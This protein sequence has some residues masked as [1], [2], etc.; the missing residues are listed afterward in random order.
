MTNPI[1]LG[2]VFIASLFIISLSFNANAAT[3]NYTVNDGAIAQ[4]LTGKKGD[5]IS[6]RKVVINRRLGNCL[7]CHTMPI[8]EQS[9]QGKIGPN[10]AGV[11]SRYKEGQL[12]L[13]I[14]NP[15]VVNPETF[16]P[17]YYRTK[18]LHRV[19]KKW[20]G[21]TILSA[22]QVEDVVAYL[23]TLREDTPFKSAFSWA[24]KAKL[25]EFEWRGKV[26]ST[27]LKAK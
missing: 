12:R 3:V 19:Q 20:R 13:R 15:K 9:F 17:A 7:A 1:K 22:Q 6:G 11:A 5:P 4:S 10:L 2:S 18:G 16:M 23:M 14:V 26:Y 24:R 8:P 27:G 21:K 25:K